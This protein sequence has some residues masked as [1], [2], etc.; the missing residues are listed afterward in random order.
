MN[1]QI[2][3][4]FKGYSGE[5]NI[6]VADTYNDAMKIIN[7]F[8]NEHHFKSYY[9]IMRVLNDKIQIDVGSH[10]EF[11]YLYCEGNLTIQEVVKGVIDE[12]IDN[13]NK[14]EEIDV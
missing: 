4:T 9:S 13:M 2:R 10:T 12:G 11:F 7:K 14:E 1:K 6:G 5:R 8:L 3:V